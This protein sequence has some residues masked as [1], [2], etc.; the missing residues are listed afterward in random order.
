MEDNIY[1]LLSIITIIVGYTLHIYIK[2]KR[3]WK[4]IYEFRGDDLWPIIGNAQW[5]TGNSV[6]E[7]N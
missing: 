6:G 2:N 1:V 4:L 3:F 7:Q 5:F